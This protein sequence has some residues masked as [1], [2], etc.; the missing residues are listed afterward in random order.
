RRCRFSAHL[1]YPS[2]CHLNQWP[3][4]LGSK[5]QR[6]YQSRCAEPATSSLLP[7]IGFKL[8]HAVF[9]LSDQTGKAGVPD[10]GSKLRT[11]VLNEPNTADANVENLPVFTGIHQTVV[12]LNRIALAGYQAC[13]DDR[14]TR[15]IA[16]TR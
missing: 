9:Q 4:C 13:A 11:I 15:I 7:F 3:V 1:A 2:R 5:S 14:Q 12:Q 10:N 6:H 16:R 8:L